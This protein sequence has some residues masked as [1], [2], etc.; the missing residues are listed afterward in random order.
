MNITDE[1]VITRGGDGDLHMITPKDFNSYEACRKSG[2]TNM[3]HLS[4][5]EDITNIKKEKIK[6]IMENYNFLH[7]LFEEEDV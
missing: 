5:V 6:I 4:V 7:K 3:Y 1:G 2:V